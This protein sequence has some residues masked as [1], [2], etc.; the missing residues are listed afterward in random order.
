MFSRHPLALP[1]MIVGILAAMIYQTVAIAAQPLEEKFQSELEKLRIELKFPGAT[2]AYI[3][4]DG[5]VGTAATGFSDVE[6]GTAMRPES[7]MLAASIGKTFVGATVVSLAQEGE[8]GLDDPISKW[9]GDRPWFSRLPNHDAITVRHLLRHTAGVPNYLGTESFAKAFSE[10]WRDPR[11]SFAPERL[12]EFVLDEPALFEPGEGWEY[13]DTAYILLGLIIEEASEHT[14]YDEVI[15]RFIVPLRMNLTSP[16]DRVILPGLAAGYLPADN[17][18]GLPEKTTITEGILV[19]NL[20][21]LLSSVKAGP[22]EKPNVRYGAGVGIYVD[23]YYGTTYGH[24]GSMP[25]Y[26]SSMRYYTEHGIAVS[27]QVNVDS[28]QI[29]DDYY[30]IERRLAALF[31]NLE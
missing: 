8:L 11:V 10:S 3:L 14:Y 20:K 28:S 13:T 15:Y 23:D 19:W 1:L 9:L 17:K 18:S 2:A 26:T 30:E 29:G 24:G 31:M 7:R 12:I 22:P 16:S 5:T 6:A 4:P 25:G 27:F 21:E